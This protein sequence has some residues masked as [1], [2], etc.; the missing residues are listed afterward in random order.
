MKPI[1]I[2]IGQLQFTIIRDKSGL[3]KLAPKYLLTLSMNNQK[4]TLIMKAVNI[5]E[6]A[7]SHYRI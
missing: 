7:T 6:S 2:E 5:F 3:N 4:V 1:P